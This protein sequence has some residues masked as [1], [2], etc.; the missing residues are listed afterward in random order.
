MDEQFQ[1]L[2]KIRRNRK[3]VR[4]GEVLIAEPFLS[5]DDFF[6]SVIYMVERNDK[7]S[8]GFVLNKPTRYRTSELVT[9]LE[10]VEIPVYIGG[11]VEQNQLYYIHRCPDL[12]DALY[13]ADGI[14]WG[15]DFRML[16]YMLREK[17]I[18]PNEIRFFA[19]YS[20]WGA[21]QLEKELEEN[22][23]MVGKLTN[24]QVFALPNHNL[25]KSA[26]NDLGGKHRIW[27]NFPENPVMN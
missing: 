25:W 13:I 10:G 12:K 11:P 16:A 27:A 7:G 9:E 26:M 20:G 3:K 24:D 8:I 2:F 17:E 23:W 5:G 6:R 19:G 22:S 18:F 4:I 14:Y 21:G 15:G 1:D